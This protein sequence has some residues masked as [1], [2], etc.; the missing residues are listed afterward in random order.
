VSRETY[1]ESPSPISIEFHRGQYYVEFKTDLVEALEA[2][3]RSTDILFI[4]D[5][6][7]QLYPEIPESIPRQTRVVPLVASEQS[8]DLLF[9]PK[10]IDGLLKADFRRGSRLVAI[11]GGIIQDIVA[12]SASILHRGVE[13]V[14][15]PTTLLAQ[16]DS[17]IGGKSS[18]NFGSFKNQIGG[19]FPPSKIVC[20]E[21]FLHTL[22]EA[23]F[24]SGVGEIAHYYCLQAEEIFG[25]FARVIPE[26]LKDRSTVTPL[27]HQTLTIKKNFIEEDEFDLA[28][29]KLLNFG[30]SFAHAIEAATHYGVP[31]GTAVA[32]GIDLAFRV[33]ERLGMV[34]LEEVEKV[35]GVIQKI[36]GDFEFPQVEAETVL[37]A[38]SHDKKNTATHL[39]LILTSG[40]GKMAVVSLGELDP[41]RSVLKECLQKY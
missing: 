12:F 2:E 16:G 35:W 20:V 17:C 36:V 38:L 28:R 18:I 21:S 37:A 4:D 10:M 8:K 13:W 22:P 25:S 5:H 30:H 15:F 40:L 14:F 9:I 31:H 33:S 29:R 41:V 19:F 7:L 6:V 1:I 23:D 3:I 34:D 11:G 24:R 32:Y 26:V 39:N 27:I